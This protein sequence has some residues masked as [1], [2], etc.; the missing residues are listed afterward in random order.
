ML[1][2]PLKKAP[3]TIISFQHLAMKPQKAGHLLSFI[4][5]C[6]PF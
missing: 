6:Y 1:Q 2:N 5:M 4:V 3:Y